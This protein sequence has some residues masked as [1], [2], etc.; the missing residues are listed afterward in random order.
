MKCALFNF[1][2]GS[3]QSFFYG[4]NEFLGEFGQNNRFSPYFR[5]GASVWEILDPPLF[6][7]NKANT[8]CTLFC[9]PITVSLQWRIYIVKFWTPGG[10]NSLNF[11]QFLGKFGKIVYWRPPGELAPPPRGNPG[12]A[13]AFKEFR[14]TGR[15]KILTLQGYF[16]PCT[17]SPDSTTFLLA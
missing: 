11:M 12:S 3:L 7:L 1:T 2:I 5:I 9:S 17:P 6:R 10:P 13:T 14:D 16:V 15:P 8:L 4:F